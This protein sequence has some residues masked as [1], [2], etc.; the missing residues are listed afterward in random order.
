MKVL[1]DRNEAEIIRICIQIALN[2]AVVGH[3]AYSVEIINLAAQLGWVDLRS[4][5]INGLY[6]AWDAVN[7]WPN[8]VPLEHKTAAYLIEA[9]DSL[10]LSKWAS[11]S[12]DNPAR[13]EKM[14]ADESGLHRL[15]QFIREHERGDLFTYSDTTST[16]RLT[17]EMAVLTALDFALR[18][19]HQGGIVDDLLKISITV[20]P[21]RMAY[22]SFPLG[23]LIAISIKLDNQGAFGPC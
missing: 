19:G 10:G 6:F 9:D 23:R 15:L 2:F 18:L 22:L 21:L 7:L 11:W 3:I 14:E 20:T 13:H 16:W 17:P 5:R 12:S 8:V 1:H 4:P